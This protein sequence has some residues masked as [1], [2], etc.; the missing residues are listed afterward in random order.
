MRCSVFGCDINNNN[1]NSDEISFHKFPSDAKICKQWVL[2]C[3]RKDKLNVKT[4]RVCSKH[5]KSEDF[6]TPN[7]IFAEYGMKV[8]VQLKRD[9]G[10]VPSL[11]LPLKKQTDSLQKHRFLQIHRMMQK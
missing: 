11:F 1:G 6:I 4:A 2:L 5:F 10:V 7:P 8:I 9:V 3:R